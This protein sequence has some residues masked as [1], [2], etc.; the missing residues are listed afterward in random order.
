MS[1]AAESKTM[2][3][4]Y[5]SKKPVDFSRRPPVVG[6]SET[7]HSIL[8]SRFLA[9]EKKQADDEPIEHPL[10]DHHTDSDFYTKRL[11]AAIRNDHL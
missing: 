6:K 8:R 9:P 4:Q 1:E 3:D 11:T 2:L 7:N 5:V 10:S